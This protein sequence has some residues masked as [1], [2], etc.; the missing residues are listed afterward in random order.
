MTDAYRS[1][2]AYVADRNRYTY[3][4]PIGEYRGLPIY[5][6]VYTPLS[7]CWNLSKYRNF[8][9]DDINGHTCCFLTG[10][11]CEYYDPELIGN[12]YHIPCSGSVNGE[13]SVVHDKASGWFST[14]LIYRTSS[15]YV[16]EW[17]ERPVQYHAFD[18]IDSYDK[19]HYYY[20]IGSDEYGSWEITTRVYQS[21]Y[22]WLTLYRIKYVWY[23][24]TSKT[25]GDQYSR[26]FQVTLDGQCPPLCDPYSWV[27]FDETGVDYPS[28][29]YEALR[30]KDPRLSVGG[31]NYGRDRG[32][33]ILPGNSDSVCL[34]LRPV[35]VNDDFVRQHRGS[36]VL[37]ASLRSKC[38]VEAMS[39]QECNTNNL[40]NALSILNLCAGLTNVNIGKLKN[41]PAVILGKAR[42]I[43]KTASETW[44]SYRYVYN[45]T[46][47]DIAEIRRFV[48]A[49]Q[50]M[51]HTFRGGASTEDGTCHVK[52][53]T[54]NCQF[55][56]LLTQVQELEKF[57]VAPDLYNL[58]DL[59]PYSFIVDWFINIGDT[60]E[61]LSAYSRTLKYDVESITTSFSWKDIVIYNNIPVKI[62]HYERLVT[63]QAPPFL[64]YKEETSTKTW[65]MRIV[66]GFAL[67][68][69]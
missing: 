23:R 15:S 64:P 18:F 29:G 67:L 14:D 28:K 41:L 4:Q 37:S 48:K 34:S 16:K 68:I 6:C 54:K 61:Q 69:S 40:A 32:W 17:Y 30:A 59:V 52:V 2:S 11:E 51:Q 39:V 27:Y 20:R 8:L 7:A 49:L 33:H 45:T 63:T 38:Y 12:P 44:L 62:S 26:T 53:K 25:Y 46:L 42:Q 65:L 31:H 9:S 43:G 36:H 10:S 19:S 66:D 47:S 1:S 21:Q 22:R 56:S 55:D 57:G 50:V 3:P 58:W 24:F 5:N 35:E 60:L 13:N